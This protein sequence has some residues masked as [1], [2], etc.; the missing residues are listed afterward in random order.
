MD[1]LFRDNEIHRDVMLAGMNRPHPEHL[2]ADADGDGL[3]LQGRE[4]PV[5]IPAAVTEAVTLLIEGV[6]RND[7]RVG[8]NDARALRHGYL[9]YARRHRDTGPPSLNCSG[10]FLSTIAG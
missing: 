7:H 8:V 9:V 1:A 10:P 3:R 2:V 4:G 6:H 5:E